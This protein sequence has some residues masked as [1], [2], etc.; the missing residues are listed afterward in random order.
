MDNLAYKKEFERL[1]KPLI[2]FLND[3]YNPH[4]KIIV[5]CT[6]AELVSGEMSTYTEEFIKD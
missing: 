3:N 6:S 1:A 5:D 4:T 2:K